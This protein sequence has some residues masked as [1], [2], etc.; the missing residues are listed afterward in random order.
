MKNDTIKSFLIGGSLFYSLLPSYWVQVKY[1]S[2][3]L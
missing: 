1:F 2:V 3:Y